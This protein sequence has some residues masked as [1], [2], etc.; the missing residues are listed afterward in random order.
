MR[1]RNIKGEACAMPGSFAL[2]K[3]R[4]FSVVS[5]K[6]Y[7]GSKSEEATERGN[8]VR[9]YGSRKRI[10]EVSVG[11][12]LSRADCAV[13]QKMETTVFAK[14]DKRWK[15]AQIATHKIV[16]LPVG[17]KRAVECFVA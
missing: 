4:K 17:E 14:G 12:P 16:E 8:S 7:A 6:V 11:V 9:F 15:R 3:F 1:A 10:I 5:H 2:K 13:M